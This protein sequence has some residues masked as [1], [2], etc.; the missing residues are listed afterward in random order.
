MPDKQNI[1][2][3]GGDSFIAKSFIQLHK[4]DF[5]FSVISRIKTDF[6]NE[7]ILTD[8]NKIPDE[9]FKHI[10][11]VINF[12][13]IV[14]QRKNTDE[15][16]YNKINYELAV[17][18]AEK[19]KNN[20]VKTFIQLST[21]AVYGNVEKIDFE[22]PENPVNPYGKSK[23]LADKKITSMADNYFKVIIFRA[24]MI[25]GL[26]N[27]PGN[28]MRL[29]GLVDKGFPL[30]F[31]NAKSKRDFIN[32]RNFIEYIDTAIKTNQTNIY[33]VS[34]DSPVSTFD[35]INLISKYLEKKVVLFSIP[36]FVLIFLKKLK[37][38]IFNK[39]Y[40]KLNVDLSKTKEILNYKPEY[41]IEQ[42]IKEMVQ[43]YLKFQNKK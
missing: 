24:P 1:L 14:H 42:G 20:G 32:I 29:I 25:Y 3:V 5:N 26:G 43:W 41:S 39:L 17:L 35:L 11:I 19:A 30:P 28:M 22:T 34:D 10:D 4:S 2:I 23:L 21:I 18:N 12:A 15:N 40:G 16:I 13:A 8:F 7:I 36:K 37:P 33:L 27:A 38:E 9:L 31:K 6:E